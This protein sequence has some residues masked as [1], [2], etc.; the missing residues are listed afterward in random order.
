[1]ARSMRPTRPVRV[2]MG[3]VGEI[4]GEEVLDDGPAPQGPLLPGYRSGEW[5]PDARRAETLR[6]YFR[7]WT[8]EPPS[9]ANMAR[10]MQVAHRIGANPAHLAALIQHESR[11][12]PQAQYGDISGTKPFNPEI[13]QGLIQFIPSTARGLGTTSQAIHAMTFDQ[14]MDLVE[15]YML[16][17]ARETLKG[18]PL[19]SLLKVALAVFQPAYMHLP[20]NTPLPASAQA[21]NPGIRTIADYTDA[22]FRSNPVLG[23]AE[24]VALGESPETAGSPP[25]SK[26]K[27]TPKLPKLPEGA[28]EAIQGGTGILLMGVFV[29]IALTA[30][31]RAAR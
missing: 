18:G 26:P 9:A 17:R 1:M 2:R 20:P 15:E 27:T 22:V 13:A 10:V 11:W 29:V 5:I 16:D 12:N 25:S 19:D 14:Q 24:R 21:A 8:G 7:T 28:G 31:S 4:E 6:R 3:G 23:S 30:G